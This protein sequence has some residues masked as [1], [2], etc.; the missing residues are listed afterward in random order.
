[1]AGRS[2]R[3]RLSRWV[4]PSTLMTRAS[5]VSNRS[6]SGGS[7][8]AERADASRRRA[9]GELAGQVANRGGHGRRAGRAAPAPSVTRT[10]ASCG[11]RRARSPAAASSSPDRAAAWS[12][13]QCCATT[14]TAAAGRAHQRLERSTGVGELEPRRGQLRRRRVEVGRGVGGDGRRGDG[15]PPPERA[16]G[17]R[18]RRPRHRRLR[19][20]RARRAP[21][22]SGRSC[23][24]RDASTS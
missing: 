3:A 7:S 24:A 10:S 11:A 20:G 9:D 22:P 23:G 18:R 2:G 12:T 5:S 19:R 13:R 16:G 15:E 14:G 8:R 4:V 21:G 17:H 6:R 1:M